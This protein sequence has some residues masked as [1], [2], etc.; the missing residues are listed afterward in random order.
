MDSLLLNAVLDIFNIDRTSYDTQS[1][2]VSQSSVQVKQRESDGV[3]VTLVPDSDFHTENR[4][5]EQVRQQ[6]STSR[7]SEAKDEVR[8]GRHTGRCTIS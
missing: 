7:N 4:D 3:Q 8:E 1:S 2:A 5:R 6:I